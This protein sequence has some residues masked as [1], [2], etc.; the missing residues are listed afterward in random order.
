MYRPWTGSDLEAEPQGE[1]EIY[2]R[3]NIL[4]LALPFRCLLLLRSLTGRDAIKA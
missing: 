1:A 4:A 3:P 2:L